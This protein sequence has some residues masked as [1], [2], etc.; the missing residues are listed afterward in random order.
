[1]T[2]GSNCISKEEARRFLVK[3]HGLDGGQGLSGKDGIMRFMNRVGCIQY[4]PLNVAGRNAD[5]VLQSRIEGYRSRLLEE[6]LYTDRSLV[7]GYDTVSYTH[8]DVY[9]RQ[10]LRELGEYLDPPVGKSG[11]NHRLRKLGELA[12][13][14]RSQQG[15]KS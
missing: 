9:K 3:Y 6:L 5:L 4:D 10:P 14:V 12:D 11:V 1:M 8:L 13:K 2:A 7:D 15:I